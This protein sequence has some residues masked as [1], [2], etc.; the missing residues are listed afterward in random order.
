MLHIYN[1]F[2]VEMF[3]QENRIYQQYV[4]FMQNLLIPRQD[5]LSD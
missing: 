5:F 2:H 3:G 4:V 1:N